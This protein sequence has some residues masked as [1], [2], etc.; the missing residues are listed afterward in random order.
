LINPGEVTDARNAEATV[1]DGSIEE[2][3][4]QKGE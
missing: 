3:L 2:A 4:G 1:T